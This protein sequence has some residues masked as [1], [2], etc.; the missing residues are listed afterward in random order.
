MIAHQRSEQAELQPAQSQIRRSIVG[1][2][3][4]IRTGIKEAAELYVGHHL[5]VGQK[6]CPCG[7]VVA[8]P[9]AAV[10]VAADEAGAAVEQRAFTGAQA[11]KGFACRAGH[12]AAV[13]VVHP[14]M[15]HPSAIHIVVEAGVVRRGVHQAQRTFH[16][17]T[18]ELVL[19]DV[20]FP[21]Q[22]VHALKESLEPL[23]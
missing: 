3:A 16:H 17:L 22:F 23:G 2:A 6:L 7:S 19:H 5:D 9:D 13:E 10:A 15:A 4:Q 18:K 12:I 11:G 21:A 20:V 8:Q 1:K 14:V